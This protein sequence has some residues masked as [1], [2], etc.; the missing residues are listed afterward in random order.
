MTEQVLREGFL[1]Q[2]GKYRILGLLGQGGFGITYEAEQVSLGRKVAVKEFFMRGSCERMEDTSSVSVPVTE[3][4]AL[5]ARFKDKFIREARLIASMEHPHIV[6]IYD[7]FEENGT[8]YYVMES[9]Q[10][11]SLDMLVKTGGP[12]P[13]SVAVEYI[14][15]IGE[16]LSYVHGCNVLHLDVKPANILLRNNKV[17]DAVLID[18]GISKHY[19]EAGQ[20]T[21]STPVGISEGYAPIEQY[22]AGDIGKFTPATDVYSLGATLYFLVTGE[23]PPTASDIIADGG[24]KRPGFMSDNVWRAISAAMTA[25]VKSRPG[26][27]AAFLA[28]LS[29]STAS[30]AALSSQAP[31]PSFPA[32]SPSFPAPTG[33]PSESEATVLQGKDNQSVISSGGRVG[34]V[35]VISSGAEKSRSGSK[36]KPLWIA[37]GAVV[38]AVI[39]AGI[40]ILGGGS[41]N[42]VEQTLD[43]ISTT[44]VADQNPNQVNTSQPEKPVN[45]AVPVN[46][47]KFEI[48]VSSIPSGAK[49]FIDGKDQKETTPAIIKDLKTGTYKV[50][51]RLEGYQEQSKSVT[52]KAGGATQSK[53]NITLNKE[54]PQTNAVS[55]TSNSSNGVYTVNGVSFKMIYVAGGTFSMGA[56]SE[57][58]SDGD[59]DE[60]PVHSVTLSSYWIGET[61]ITQELWQAVMGSNPSRFT[62]DSRR[63]VEQVSYDDCKTFISKLNSLTGKNFRLPTEAE[64]EY[65]ARGGNKSRGYKYS[66]SNTLGDVAWYDGNSGSTTHPVKTKRANELGIYDMSGNVWEWCN[67]WYGSYSSGSQTNPRGAGSGSDR[68]DRGGSWRSLARGCR[69]SSRNGST[70]SFRYNFLG[71]RLAI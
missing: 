61:E 54:I 20:Q 31:S 60:K 14:K 15:Q 58:G 33:N 40:F 25:A 3:S 28:L 2:G 69:V 48:V 7:V 34:N 45:P 67:D 6:K 65:A 12:L 10:G 62:G 37:I 63:P 71:L 56:T 42:S 4:R 22:R 30:A 38:T 24:L 57:Q 16:A 70:P 43:T 26:S 29:S 66:G 32:S 1:L 9:I 49:V 41:K 47:E 64:W 27:V 55:S 39:I 8:A 68:V 17:N 46:E 50:T 52:F 36:K 59:D 44:V 51:L 13:E 19:D 35:S 23:V 5:V 11:G 53:V 18:F 21:S